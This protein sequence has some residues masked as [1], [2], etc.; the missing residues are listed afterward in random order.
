MIV[1]AITI[2]AFILYSGLNSIAVAILDVARAI[3]DKKIE[4][5]R[6]HL[7]DKP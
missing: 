7:V 6:N 1:V 4:Q 2:S 3:R 5:D